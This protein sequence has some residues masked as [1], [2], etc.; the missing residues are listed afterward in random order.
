MLLPRAKQAS[1]VLTVLQLAARP[2]RLESMLSDLSVVDSS[3]PLPVGTSTAQWANNS[4]P[5]VAAW[6][7][8]GFAVEGLGLQNPMM[9]K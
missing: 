4:V 3:K 5:L 7:K 6:V 2:S 9:K 8:R 1:K